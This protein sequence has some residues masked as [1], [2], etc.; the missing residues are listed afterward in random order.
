MEAL[1]QEVTELIRMLMRLTRRKKMMMMMT[2]DL[3]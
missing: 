2:A 3:V 1:F